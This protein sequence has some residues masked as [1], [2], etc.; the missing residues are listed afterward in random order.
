[1]PVTLL[2]NIILHL[3]KRNAEVKTPISTTR[4]QTTF[5]YCSFFFFFLIYSLRILGYW[6][7]TLYACFA[8]LAYFGEFALFLWVGNARLGNHNKLH[9]ILTTRTNKTIHSSIRRSF[10]H[11]RTYFICTFIM[12]CISTE[13]KKKYKEQNKIHTNNPPATH[14]DW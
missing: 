7:Y 12:Y 9:F 5:P 2:C 1:M 10:T 6:C 8:S 4:A 11:S 13:N 14:T 3:S